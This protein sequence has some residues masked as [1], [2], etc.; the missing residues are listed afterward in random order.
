MLCAS[1]LEWSTG[2]RLITCRKTCLFIAELSTCLLQWTLNTLLLLDYKSNSKPYTWLKPNGG[3]VLSST[4]AGGKST[5]SKELGSEEGH[6]D[7]VIDHNS[8]KGLFL[9]ENELEIL[10]FHDLPLNLTDSILFLCSY[11]SFRFSWRRTW[12]VQSQFCILK[13]DQGLNVLKQTSR[14]KM[15]KP[16]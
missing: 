16:S 3:Q 8:V 12:R 2:K 14:L 13:N 5:L 10:C 9:S 11:D 6:K 1:L 4:R 15:V 7:W